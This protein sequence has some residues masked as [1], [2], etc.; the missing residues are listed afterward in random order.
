MAGN[1]TGIMMD[2]P[3]IE[4]VWQ[5]PK[6]GDFF[7]VRDSYMEDDDF[8]IIATDGRRFNYK[9][10]NDY[11]QT[12]QKIEELKHSRDMIR[13]KREQDED[14]EVLKLIGSDEED[15]LTKPL[16]RNTQPTTQTPSGGVEMDDEI[17]SL[18][19]NY[20]DPG[21]RPAGVRMPIDALD[22]DR[23]VAYKQPAL[24]DADIIGRA[25]KRVK[26]PEIKLDLIFEKYPEKQLDMLVNL[27]GCEYEDIA[28]WM[29]EEYFSMDLKSIIIDKIKEM[30]E[31]DKPEESVVI[32]EWKAPFPSKIQTQETINIDANPEE[33][34]V[35]RVFV[36]EENIDKEKS[37]V[38]KPTTKK[39]P[40]KRNNF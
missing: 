22:Y 15:I 38:K 27:M 24:K 14:N 34:I 20:A 11:S 17:N 8:I 40:I 30:L 4:G 19:G 32:N 35:E 2:G 5:N 3:T 1:F 23:S 13:R 37:V 9:M 12:N 10:L 33:N 28:N 31:G 39:K 21:K 6:T 16:K 36:P 29:Y 26:A 18:M 25:L 7:T